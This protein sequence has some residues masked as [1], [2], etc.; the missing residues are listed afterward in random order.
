MPDHASASRSAAVLGDGFRLDGW[1]IRPRAHELVRG[2]EVVRVEPKP[3]EVLVCLAARAGHTVTRD[4]LLDAVWPEVF[5]SES[6][7]S[8][9]V[10]QLRKVFG[11]DP[12]A[13]RVI[14]TI[15]RSGYRLIAPVT[16]LTA[17]D[18]LATA[19]DGEF[20]GVVTLDIAP[21]ALPASQPM[22]AVP[23]K[24]RAGRL[25]VVLVG[26]VVLTL[27]ALALSGRWGGTTL[28]PLTVTPFDLEPGVA[29]SAA[30]SPDGSRVAYVR[31]SDDGG[32]P[33]AALL[34]R[35][36]AD[37]PPLRLDDGTAYVAA[38]AWSPDGIE[39]AF[40]RC[41][42]AGCRPYAVPALGGTPRRLAE[43]LVSPSGIAWL[44]DGSLVVAPR[45][46]EGEPAPLARL[47]LSTGA[48]TPLTAPPATARGDWMPTPSPDG[49]WLAFG[50]RTVA[51]GQDL[52]RL[53]LADLDAPPER[54]TRDDA[55]LAGVTWTPDGR[56]LLLSSN[57]TGVYALWRLDPRRG[58]LTPVSSV[59]ARDPGGP[60]LAGEALIF[61]EWLFEINLWRYDLADLEAEPEWLVASSAWDM[62]PHYSKGGQ[63]E[64]GRL[65]FVSNRSGPPELWLAD[66]DGSRAQRRTQ[67]D[68]PAVESPR[69]HPD[70]RRL[71]VQTRQDERAVLM[72]LDAEG[73]PPQPL[74]TLDA[75]AR[76]P[77][78]S[79]DGTSVLFASNRG[80]TWQL[81]R[82]AIEGGTPER[83]PGTAGAIVGAE[84][85]DGALLVARYGEPGLWRIDPDSDNN[86]DSREATPL[87]ADLA[88]PLA[89]TVA[90]DA[91]VYLA[92]SDSAQALVRWESG[93]G[94]RTERV[95]PSVQRLPGT[96]VLTAS[97]DG[98]V[99]VFA[100]V[101][102][103]ESDLVRVD[104]F[105]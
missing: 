6:T 45:P 47:D 21:P 62:H 90:D 96:P 58:T 57:R 41:A 40:V 73:G 52:Y 82:V 43:V 24:S 68:G 9:C 18:G 25:G 86:P 44:S 103:I 78:W 49:R 92:Q 53:D 48:V 79:Q 75:D 50:R 13:P 7:L 22:S 85:P 11:D 20:E 8:R 88:D 35:T 27:A 15:P 12:Q 84:G 1:T 93:S 42:D 36:S 19:F 98:T 65:A 26:M 99:I 77:R 38:P 71:V 23:G 67:F 16:P 61:E 72:L 39:I 56:A 83:I 32:R 55:D 63:G 59:P 46:A 5:V 101:D 17:G 70:G 10:S 64:A 87:L 60:A 33:T 51:G 34:V 95:L 74:T 76:H 100:Q 80:G 30:W 14:E 104:G 102:H 29:S 89:W 69:W 31:R 94:Q 81:W 37:T 66:A 91:L 4:E 54:L 2:T 28:E 105:K 3:M 97:A